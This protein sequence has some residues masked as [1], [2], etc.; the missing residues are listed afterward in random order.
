MARAF[1]AIILWLSSL[2]GAAPPLPLFDAHI[3]Y[4]SDA[5][6]GLPVH[7]ALAILDRAGI[8]RALVSSTPD[9]GTLK[10]H[11]A[12]PARIVPELRP[13]RRPE[14]MSLWHRD[15]S[16]VPYIEE[17]LRRGGYRGIGEFHLAPGQGATPVVRRVVELA[18]AREIPI[19]VHCNAAA[20]EELL[21]LDSRVKV[22]WA[23]AGMSEPPPT[24]ERMIE[25][26]PRLWVE[27]SYRLDDVA[28]GGRL[29]AAWRELFLRHPARFLYGSDTWTPSRWTEVPALARSARNWLGELPPE[30]AEG[31]A[32]RNAEAL[33]GN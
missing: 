22:L 14:D 8:T 21:A 20:L 28:P 4:S 31:I 26:H 27:L 32:W 5:W 33:Y 7:E 18:V 1:P 19:H 25:L 9:D 6:N 13:Y 12:A 2:A 10:L 17:R 30:V 24:V 16:V 3:H 23:H 29:D 11:Q 15:P